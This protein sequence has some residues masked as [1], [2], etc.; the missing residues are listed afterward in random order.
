MVLPSRLRSLLPSWVL[1]RPQVS[2]PETSWDW[3]ERMPRKHHVFVGSD[4]DD[5]VEC[6]VRRKSAFKQGF[7]MQHTSRRW[8]FWWNPK[9]GPVKISLKSRIMHFT[10]WRAVSGGEPHWTL[11]LLS[12]SVNYR[13]M[14]PPWLIKIY[15]KLKY[16][17]YDI[18][19][20]KKHTNEHF[21]FCYLLNWSWA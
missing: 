21:P 3:L 20:G 18:I 14:N 1:H 16:T 17:S 11:P 7:T 19:L 9:Q 13:D 8:S 2:R 10:S 4:T 12:D 6:D 5:S 15:T